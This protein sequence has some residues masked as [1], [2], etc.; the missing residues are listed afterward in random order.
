MWFAQTVASSLAERSAEN[1]TGKFSAVWATI[2]QAVWGNYLNLET[3]F[4]NFRSL[5][6]LVLASGL[7]F[8]ACRSASS[9]DDGEA[10][11]FSQDASSVPVAASTQTS[12]AQAPPVSKSDSEVDVA[13]SGYPPESEDP[14]LCHVNEQVKRIKV[15]SK[16]L[17]NGVWDEIITNTEHG[18]NRSPQLSWKPVS[19]AHE[20]AVYMI[21]STADNWIHWRLH[22][23]KDTGLLEG[24]NLGR[25]LSFRCEYVG[26]YPPVGLTHTYNVYVFALEDKARY[27]AGLFDNANPGLKQLERIKDSLDSN[28]RIPLGNILAVGRLSGTYTQAEEI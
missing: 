17:H 3:M 24:A 11:I 20:Y 16:N 19:G 26:P 13:D 2:R 27:Y 9:E 7:A 25:S 5:M 22:N 21:D 28:K 1:A 6:L 8:G 18:K 15:T 14:L 10:P 12:Q 23:F 4:K